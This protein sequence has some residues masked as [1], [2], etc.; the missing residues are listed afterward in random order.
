MVEFET[1]V[2]RKEGGSIVGAEVIVIGE[3][4]EN[5]GSIVITSKTEYD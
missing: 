1:Q 2:Y 4:G 3:D 5:I